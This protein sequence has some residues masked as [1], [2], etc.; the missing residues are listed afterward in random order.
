MA[1][2][3]ANHAD[4]LLGINQ[5]MLDNLPELTHAHRMSCAAYLKI[6]AMHGVTLELE[7]PLDEAGEVPA[8]V[9][10]GLVIRCM[11]PR[12]ADLEALRLSLAGGLLGRLIRSVL[13]G[14]QLELTAEGG[15]GRLT[16]SAERA[17]EQLL[18]ALD[19]LSRDKLPGW[20]APLAPGAMVAEAA[21]HG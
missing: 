21:L 1:R 2:M 5:A 6:G 14:H 7:A 13:N 4:A 20:G 10:Q 15:R 17:R 19:G 9:Q 18:D 16:R 12:G 3:L 8:L 11:I